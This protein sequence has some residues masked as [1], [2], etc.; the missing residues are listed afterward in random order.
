MVTGKYGDEVLCSF[1]WRPEHVSCTGC[2]S[3]LNEQ[4]WHNTL[5]R[6]MRQSWARW[7]SNLNDCM[8][9]FCEISLRSIHTGWGIWRHRKRE[10]EITPSLSTLL[11][12]K[13]QPYIEKPYSTIQKYRSTTLIQNILFSEKL[14]LGFLHWTSLHFSLQFFLLQTSVFYLWYKIILKLKWKTLSFASL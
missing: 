8:I 3:C 11:F 7:S 6:W 12:Q 10:E 13:H 1:L 2:S 9:L 4:S 5:R 14:F